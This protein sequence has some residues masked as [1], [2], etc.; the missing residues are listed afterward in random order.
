[1]DNLSSSF[2]SKSDKNSFGNMVNKLKEYEILEKIGAG[3][4]SIVYKVRLKKDNIMLAM[5]IIE[6]KAGPEQEK[7]IKREIDN[8]I[9]C[10]HWEDNYNTL[11]LFEYFE[12]KEKYILVFNYCEKNLEEYIKENYKD[13]KMPID[14]IKLLFLGLNKGFNNLYKENVIHRD[15]KINNIM[16]EYR[17]GDKNDII[18]R[19]GDFGISREISTENNPMTFSIS[20]AFLSAPEILDSGTDYSFASDL[21][22]IGV[23]LYKLA[24]GKYPY[25][26]KG[27]VQ[28]YNTI[29]YKPSKFEK[30]G[31]KDFDDL[32]IKLLEKDKDKRITYDEYFKHPFFKYEEPISIIDFNKKYNMNISSYNR[33]FR[34]SNL[35]GNILLKDLS[36]VEFNKLKELS[37]NYSFISDISPLEHNVFKNLVFLNLQYNHIVD[38]SP[39]KNIQFLEIKQIFLGFNMIRDISPL[40]DI[41]FKCLEILSLPG[42]QYENDETNKN[43]IRS[44]IVN[45][46]YI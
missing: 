1:M 45:L 3:R 37:I 24:F 35:N 32:I 5:K 20:E 39:L 4:F 13:K 44:K 40:K 10:Y 18:P 25:E 38:I 34:C 14:E 11:K 31:N 42:N 7:Q 27:A 2:D 26:G 8:L 41:P 36:E 23:L 30:S 46:K 9:K 17:L 29:M 28:L 33:E 19:L 22:S 15:I 21:W 16:I 43:I 12:T 6:K